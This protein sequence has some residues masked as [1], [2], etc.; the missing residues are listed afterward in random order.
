ME[1]ILVAVTLV[2]LI[3]AVVL[4]IAAWHLSREERARRQARVAAL[5]AAAAVPQSQVPV[6]QAASSPSRDASPIELFASE[7]SR[8]R[9]DF[10]SDTV[11]DVSEP[12]RPAPSVQPSSSGPARPLAAP[13]EPELPLNSAAESTE[14]RAASPQVAHSFLDVDPPRASDGRQ[15]GLAAAAAVLFVV[16]AGGGYW[17]ISKDGMAASGATA[18]AVAPL[19]LMSLRHE[20]VGNR[21]TLTGLV[22]NPSAGA[23]VN[24]LNAVVFLFDAKGNYLSTA[25]AG[26]DF[27]HLAPGDESP[28]VISVDAPAQVARY[29]ISF[30]TE[31]GVLAH[32]DRRAEQRPVAVAGT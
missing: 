31:A 12:Q 20:R 2:S 4:G 9:T 18:A 23:P 17:L 15:R 21:L 13:R 27:T 7:S 32:V 29:R 22:R 30:R 10:E 26:V 28:F 19:E 25:R 11:A 3:V 14:T 5:A 1:S 24:G 8:Q 16:L 6:Q